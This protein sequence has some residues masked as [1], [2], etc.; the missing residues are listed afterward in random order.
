M[1]LARCNCSGDISISSGRS[2]DCFICRVDTLCGGVVG[3]RSGVIELEPDERSGD[4][5]STALLSGRP[6]AAFLSAPATARK[7]LDSS[8]GQDSSIPLCTA[9]SLHVLLHPQR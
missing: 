9:T 1:V 5:A 8:C 7:N 2:K 6:R 3:S 4:I